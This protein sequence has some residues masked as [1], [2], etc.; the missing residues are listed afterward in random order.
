MDNS[1]N[2]L[3]L[4]QVPDRAMWFHPSTWILKRSSSVYSVEPV[5]VRRASAISVVVKALRV[6]Q[7]V[8]NLLLFVPL[9]MAHRMMESD[10]LL[11]VLVA[12]IAFNLCASSGYV[13]NDLLDL[14]SDRQ[15]PAKRYRPFATGFLQIRTGLLLASLLLISG[16]AV[17]LV[18]LSPPFSASL[19]LYVILSTG[20]SFYLKRLLIM[21]VMVLAGL[22]ALRVFAGGVA[23]AITISPW[24]LAFSMFLFLSLAFLKRYAELRLMQELKQ[25]HHSG[26]SYVLSDIDL[27]RSIGPASGYLSVLVLALYINSKE[28]MVLY[29]HPAVLWLIGPCLFYWLTNVWFLAHR[30]EMMDDPVVFALKDRNSYALG[31]VILSVIVAASF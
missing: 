7:W 8:K 18:F 10:M 21:D 23:V 16:F 29:R 31:V 3:P 28:V 2:S 17:A 24:L 12:F 6:H 26:R 14:E 30:G 20:Y 22:Y 1:K 19:A 9:I 27:L 11:Q 25:V 4:W 5:L 15:H 13:V